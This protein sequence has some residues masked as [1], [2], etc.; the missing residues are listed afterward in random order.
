MIIKRFASLKDSWPSAF[1]ARGKV[2]EF[3]GGILNPRSM[4]NADCAGIGPKDKIKIGR[5]IAYS[6]E[7]LIAY[8]E[9]RVV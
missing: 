6:V 1:V 2:E 3:S 5:K 4:A 9:S 8:M 7:A